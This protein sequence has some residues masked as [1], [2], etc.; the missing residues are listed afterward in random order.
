MYFIYVDESGNKDPYVIERADGSK[1][2]NDKVYVLTGV[3]LF[4]R[5]WWG[6]DNTIN[7]KKRELID[8]IRSKHSELL[9]FAQCEIKSNW[10][11]IPKERG[12][13]PFLSK[14]SDAELE[15]L[16]KLYYAQ[17]AYN[18]M[19][20]FSIVIDKTTLLPFFDATKIQRKAW[21]L[22]LERIQNF[23]AAEHGKHMAILITD[24]TGRHAN[25]SL[26][27][28]HVY[29]QQSGTSSGLILRHI[30][31]MPLFVR[32]ELSNGVQL[33][34]L[35]SYNIYRAFKTRDMD[36]IHFLN[37]LPY[38]YS[39]KTSPSEKL[40]GLKIF[41]PESSLSPLC[42]DAGEKRVK[43]IEGAILA[44]RKRALESDPPEP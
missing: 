11:R 22:L 18:K 32:S 41:P 44:E 8:K 20:I 35:V 43:L 37:I 25:Q 28:K 9:T 23:M 30:V 21:E 1:H 34:D 2:Y 42:V 16:I 12:N 15:N 19:A 24:D 40:D 4:S 31:E 39:G 7:I 5:R 10:V 36:Y 27:M 38:I 3:A 13:H 33:A 17:L 6:F 26:A 14:I 29:L